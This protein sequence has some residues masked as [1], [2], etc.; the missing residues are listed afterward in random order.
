VLLI[1]LPVTADASDAPTVEVQPSPISIGLSYPT[2]QALVILRNAGSQ[3][4]TNP[5]LSYFSND[6]FEVNLPGTHIHKL[7]KGGTL[8]W[9]IKI[10]NIS[11][12]HVPGTIVFDVV[13]N[14]NGLSGVHQMATLAVNAPADPSPKA[15]DVSIEGNFDS[16]SEVRPG[17]GHVVFTNNLD[18]PVSVAIVPEFAPKS[19]APLKLANTNVSGR[20]MVELPFTLSPQ[21]SIVP[22]TYSI[23]FEIEAKW[24]S[25]GHEETRHLVVSKPAT[26]GLFFES[27]VLKALGVP[28]F[29]ILPGCLVIFAMQLLLVLGIGGLKDLSRLPSL[30]VTSP[31]FWILAVF[32][33]AAFAWLYTLFTGRNYLFSYGPEDLRNVWLISIGIGFLAYGVIAW[34]SSEY[35]RV[36]VP[37][38][39][40][41]PITILKKMERNG[42]AIEPLRIDFAFKNSQK[43]AFVIETVEDDQTTLWVAPKI[44]VVW[45]TDANA[46]AAQHHFE[47]S[48][49]HGASA[50]ALATELETAQANGHIS[51]IAWDAHESVPNPF[52]L[53]T[54]LIA[55][56]LPRARLV[57]SV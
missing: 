3:T 53:K 30:T 43:R 55:G 54:E 1:L 51:S 36:H 9:P 16:V 2:A 37:A 40:D 23:G 4:L 46:A 19:F 39:T 56:W 27:D 48:L 17:Y 32:I 57:E 41:T 11:K 18:V 49:D 34:W 7:A 31:G 5:S 22:G 10:T 33:S 6:G 47:Q 45:H 38:S 29:L 42:I 24:N 20:S 26:V 8:V 14:T 13:Y 25:A 35:R 21:S 52:H 28:S 15:L 50:G 12:A 44:R